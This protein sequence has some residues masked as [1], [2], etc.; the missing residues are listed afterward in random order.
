MIL[1][2]LYCISLEQPVSWAMFVG[3]PADS[4]QMLDVRVD[5][6]W[7]YIHGLRAACQLAN[8]EQVEVHDFFEWL[9]YEKGEFPAEGWTTKY[10]NDC[11]GNHL[12]AI[13]KFWSF[14]HEYLL[15]KKPE[16]FV[17]LNAEP[18]PSEVR[19]YIGEP[20]NS[21]IRDPE[22]IRAVI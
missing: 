8:V 18:L 11:G 7:S 16:W 10:L 6:L 20:R 22:H 4:M 9:I 14:L 1:E 12:E 21:D 19:N 5:S 15:A 2:H 13:S 3:M 17:R